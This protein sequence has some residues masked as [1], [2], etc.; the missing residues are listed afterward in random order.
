[1]KAIIVF[2]SAIFCVAAK[3]YAPRLI[4]IKARCRIIVANWLVREAL[5]AEDVR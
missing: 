5:R 1:L 3:E 2:V 4:C